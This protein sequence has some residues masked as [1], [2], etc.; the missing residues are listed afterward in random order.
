MSD[1]I[2]DIHGY[3]QLEQ[4][5][6]ELLVVVHCLPFAWNNMRNVILTLYTRKETAINIEYICV[7]GN[8][9]SV[10]YTY[11]CVAWLFSLRNCEGVG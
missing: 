1:R 3:Q 4:T 8:A 10:G 9:I 6:H 7:G 2:H 11:P 5:R